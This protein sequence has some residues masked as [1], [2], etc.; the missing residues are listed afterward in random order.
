MT[1]TRPFFLMSFRVPPFQFAYPP[2]FCVHTF[3]ENLFGA[4]RRF[5]QFFSSLPFKVRKSPLLCFFGRPSLLFS[6]HLFWSFFLC[7]SHNF[8][9]TFHPPPRF[10]LAFTFKTLLF[11]LLGYSLV[12]FAYRHDPVTSPT[13][14]RQSFLWNFFPHEASSLRGLLS[15]AEDPNAGFFVI[16]PDGF[17]FFGV[18]PLYFPPCHTPNYLQTYDNVFGVPRFSPKLFSFFFPFW[19]TCT[20]VMGIGSRALPPQFQKELPSLLVLLRSSRDHYTPSLGTRLSHILLLVL[21][22]HATIPTMIL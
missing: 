14:F 9:R 10:S 1:P 6:S 12:L 17:F 8:L 21:I 2:R 13:R 5:P 15:V 11:L 19:G 18:L 4:L 7:F 22:Y 20:P 3:L 16:F